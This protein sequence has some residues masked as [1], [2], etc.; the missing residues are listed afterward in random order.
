M[1]SQT[2]V[3]SD[4]TCAEN[5]SDGTLSRSAN[6][7]QVATLSTERNMEELS[8]GTPI[9]R[10]TED[11]ASTLS[12]VILAGSIALTFAPFLAIFF[13]R[14]WLDEHHRSFPMILIA[15]AWLMH[16][17][18]P[19]PSVP[20]RQRDRLIAFLALAAGFVLLTGAVILWS[21]WLGFVA[22][23]FTLLFIL[24]HFGRG[25]ALPQ[26]F[27]AWLLLWFLLP[28]P[29]NLDRQLVLG[30]QAISSQWASMWLDVLEYN[31]VL[32]GHVIHIPSQRFVVEEACSGSN[33]FFVL[34]GLT[35]IAVVGLRY[36]IL[37]G[38]LLL[39]TTFGWAAVT[40]TMR[41]VAL[42]IMRVS[43]GVDL[44]TGVGH[45]VLGL[46]TFAIALCL[47]FSTDRLLL[48]LLAPTA[49]KP[50]PAKPH[51][52]RTETGSEAEESDAD[53]TKSNPRPI[54]I[55]HRRPLFLAIA[56]VA[57]S[58]S[59]FLVS[60]VE[61]YILF[62]SPG[63]NLRKVFVGDNSADLERLGG[64]LN[65]SSIT[66]LQDGWEFVQF[67]K[68]QV[69]QHP[70][71]SSTWTFRRGDVTALIS[72]D[73][74]FLGWHELPTC[75][76]VQGWD[77]RERRVMNTLRHADEEVATLEFSLEKATGEFGMVMVSLFDR[78]GERLPPPSTYDW[79]WKG[80]AENAM[81]RLGRYGIEADH[82]RSLY[83][84]QV[85]VTSSSPLT[86]NERE[87][88]AAFYFVAR[89]ELIAQLA[90]NPPSRH[91]S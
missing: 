45:T 5:A 52:E 67:A 56:T 59:F 36:P 83:Q 60:A 18:W 12:N 91:G 66:T 58:V 31:H 90:K 82:I 22:A 78:T 70:V 3:G 40:N 28:L 17:R 74:P 26:L 27:S 54:V 2:F 68:K 1:I 55:H 62:T 25:E 53:E 76:T 88:V 13:R 47:L 29:A 77:I 24:I 84:F 63:A 87:K 14:L 72:L 89:K 35:A 79:S 46:F 69:D 51:N 64:S 34:L 16:V 48:F 61:A 8:A 23:L 65:A 57:V 10:E 44:S 20:L 19:D 7:M 81:S 49:V 50:I 21:A 41:I 37:P 15:A 85:L 43:A 38:V 30:L 86:S 71:R 11:R 4:G 75:Y 73:Y 39:A 80:L 32:S 6:L 42:V 33:S 9:R